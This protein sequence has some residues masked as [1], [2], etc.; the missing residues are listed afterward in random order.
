MTE[1]RDTSYNITIYIV[2]FSQERTGKESERGDRKAK[3]ISDQFFIFLSD[4]PVRLL[5]TAVFDPNDN[6]LCDRIFDRVLLAPDATDDAKR[7]QRDAQRALPTQALR[8]A[9]KTRRRLCS[10]A[11]KELHRSIFLPKFRRSRPPLDFVRRKRRRSAT[12]SDNLGGV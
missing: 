2:C 6:A 9:V 4:P 10:R 11:K 7:R 1:K 12:R 5:R 3:K 8:L